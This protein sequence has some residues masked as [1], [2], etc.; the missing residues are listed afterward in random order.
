MVRIAA[1]PAAVQLAGGQV[2][3]DL[4]PLLRSEN[5]E[6]IQTLKTV[7]LSLPAEMVVP[8]LV[9]RLEHVGAAVQPS[10]LEVLAE[11]R[12]AEAVDKVFTL[13]E[14]EEKDVRKAAI[15]NLAAFVGPDDLPR[16]LRLLESAPRS[17][18]R[19]IQDA[20]VAGANQI[21][22]PEARADAIL[23]EITASHE[24]KKADLIRPLHRIGGEQ[25]LQVV[26]EEAHN[27]DIRVKTAA[28][29][30]LSQWPD[31]AAAPAL[32][33]IAQAS[34]ERKFT[35][36][37]LQGYVRLK[38][39]VPLFNGRDL[40]G[41]EGDTQGYVAE[42]N[43][44]VVYP[45]RGS[46]NLYTEKEYQDFI[47]IFEFQLTPG[48]NNGLGIRTP[49]EGDAAYVGMELQILDNSAAKYQELK[50]YQYHGSIYG[51]VPAKRGF[52][53]P[54]GEWNFQE[55]IAQGR[56]ITVRLNGET[57]VDADIDEAATP[58][59]LDGREHPGL[60][61]NRG[62]IGFLGHGSRVAFR[63]I[64]IKEIE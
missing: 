62:H 47:L 15:S 11:R 6:Q 50:E 46:G 25:A 29:Y 22:D 28:I 14:S 30:T 37:A 57:I 60:K 23:V 61:R 55:V 33:E 53:R 32:L 49:R 51:V 48:A 10:V 44:I 39:F 43:Q 7:F 24:T 35:S 59:T 27:P 18:I 42:D 2:M 38:E 31:S 17:E 58:Q 26:I 52:Q 1:I 13:I 12:A 19:S 5:M 45:D 41:W 54:V 36:L 3:P 34:R 16:L 4:L 8:E 40:S 9:A 21:S 63:N 56:R 64:W 20:I